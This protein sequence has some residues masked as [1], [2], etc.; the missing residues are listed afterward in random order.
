MD[1]QLRCG[2]ISLFQHSESKTKDF[3][4]Q[5]TCIYHVSFRRQLIKISH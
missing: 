2:N 5:W 1:I 4:T 3:T